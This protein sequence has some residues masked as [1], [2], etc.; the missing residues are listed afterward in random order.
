MMETQTG[1]SY[2]NVQ[3]HSVFQSLTF[4]LCISSL[5]QKVFDWETCVVAKLVDDLQFT[6]Q[7][8]YL[9][10][11]SSYLFDSN[12]YQLKNFNSFKIARNFSRNFHILL[13]EH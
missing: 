2:T 3:I 5:R 1:S 9:V 10:R 4:A 7:N 6:S 13:V 11:L 12:P 8:L